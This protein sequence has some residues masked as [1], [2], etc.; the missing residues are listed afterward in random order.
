MLRRLSCLSFWVKASKLIY[1]KWSIFTA[2]H[3]K[4][5]ISQQEVSML[6]GLAFHCYSIGTPLISKHNWT[7]AP[8]YPS[9]KQ[10]APLTINFKSVHIIPT[11]FVC[12]SLCVFFYLIV[13]FTWGKT[14]SLTNTIFVLLHASMP[15]QKTFFLSFFLSFYPSFISCSFFLS[16]IFQS[17]SLKYFLR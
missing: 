13:S 12:P 4:L 15:I 2:G 17:W 11:L 8:N 16:L 6:W 9:S 1:N 14:T 3:W 5:C 10:Q 7:L